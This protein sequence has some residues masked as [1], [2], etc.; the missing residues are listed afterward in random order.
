MPNKL[1]DAEIKK[2]LECWSKVACE[3]NCEKCSIGANNCL[4][5]NLEEISL[6]L[7][8]RQQAEI[9][10]LNKEAQM[11]DGYAEA[12][13]ERAKAEAYKECIEKVKTEIKQALESNHK[14][15]HEHIKKHY[16]R[17]SCDFLATV[18]GKIDAL[19]GLDYFLDNLYKELVGEDK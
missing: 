4:Q 14:A 12:L 10:R 17:L 19:S 2:A 16:Y 13:E 6:D 3:E 8:N 11:A 15:K 1:T 7:I 18:R 9:E 5:L